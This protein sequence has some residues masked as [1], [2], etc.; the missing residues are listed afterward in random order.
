MASRTSNRYLN[1]MPPV[2]VILVNCTHACNRRVSSFLLPPCLRY[3]KARRCSTTGRSAAGGASATETG[4]PLGSPAMTV[5]A[6][7][8]PVCNVQTDIPDDVTARGGEC[9]AVL[10]TVYPLLARRALFDAVA[11]HRTP[12]EGVI[13][14][15]DLFPA[16]QRSAWQ[17]GPRCENSWAGMETSL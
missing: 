15:T 12:Q 9:R 14:S 2:A 1:G 3:C 10:R 11:G 5:V 6:A 16:V 8:A 17:A 7:S 4:P 13:V